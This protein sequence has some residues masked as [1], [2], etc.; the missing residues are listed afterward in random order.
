MSREKLA[1]VDLLPRIRHKVFLVPELAPLFGLRNEDLLES[2]SILTR[3]LDGQ[4][5]STDSAFTANAVTSGDYL[6]AWIGCTT[7]IPHS[8][9]KTM[10]KLG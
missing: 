8:V 5:L 9:W 10:G 2:F 1:E 4:G 6:F 7:P 3:V